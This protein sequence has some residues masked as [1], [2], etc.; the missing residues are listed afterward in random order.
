MIIAADGRR[1]LTFGTSSAGTTNHLQRCCSFS[2][3]L[4]LVV[5]PY[6]PAELTIALLRNDV[7]VVINAYGGLR[8]GIE[9]RKSARS[10]RRRR[11]IPT[12]GGPHGA[13]SRRCR[14][15]G[16]SW[17][18]LYTPVGTPPEVVAT[19][20]RRSPKS[21]GEDIQQRHR[22][23]GSGQPRRAISLQGMRS[24]NRWGKVINKPASSNSNNRI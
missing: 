14:F 6:R 19:Q 24:E 15:R 18:G 5:V 23:S 13:G 16:E 20:A 12:S 8:Q 11:R 9:R 2:E 1:P 3:E 22:D 21:G 4:N 17:N 7:D 10:R